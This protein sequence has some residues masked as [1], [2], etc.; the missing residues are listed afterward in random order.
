MTPRAANPVRPKH[1]R[2]PEAWEKRKAYQKAWYRK[3]TARQLERT[4]AWRAA[5]RER[6]RELKRIRHAANPAKIAVYVRA[7]REKN[8]ISMSW[9]YL[10]RR[11]AGKPYA[12]KA[13]VQALWEKQKGCCGLTGAPIPPGVRPCLD[14]IVPVAKGGTHTIENIRWTHPMANKAKGAYSDDE[15]AAWWNSRSVG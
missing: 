10:R 15:F 9:Q 6:V 4:N 11:A 13:E 3:N 8:F 12:S 1:L 5:N 2:D 7:W 14:H